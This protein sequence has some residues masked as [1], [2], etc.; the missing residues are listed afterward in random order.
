MENVVKSVRDLILEFPGL[1]KTIT[2][3]NGSEFMNAKAIEE[4]GIEYFYAHSYCSYE[5]GTNE[6]NNKLIRIHILGNYLMVK[7]QK[8]FIMKNLLKKYISVI[9]T[10]AI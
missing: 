2:S 8:E 7:V 5:R 6:N 4:M 1:I 9:L 3:D 10:V